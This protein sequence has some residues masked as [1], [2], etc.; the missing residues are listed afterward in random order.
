MQSS[1]LAPLSV[2]LKASQGRCLSL[3]PSHNLQAG[4]GPKPLRLHYATKMHLED[5][6]LPLQNEQKVVPNQKGFT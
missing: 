1:G 6:F 3:N 5:S 4:G 2:Y